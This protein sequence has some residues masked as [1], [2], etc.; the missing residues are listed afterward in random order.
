LESRG[1]WGKSEKESSFKYLLNFRNIILGKENKSKVRGSRN[2]RRDLRRDFGG[3]REFRFL[4]NKQ[5]L[6]IGEP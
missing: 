3:V 5:K 2:P 4:I 1:H 6:I